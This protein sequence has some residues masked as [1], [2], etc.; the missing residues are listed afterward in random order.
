MRVFLSAA[1]SFVRCFLHIN[2][3]VHRCSYFVDVDM[4]ISPILISNFILIPITMLMQ[5]T[6]SP[7]SRQG[8]NR[9]VMS[10][11][12][13]ADDKFLF[14][15]TATGDILVIF[16]ASL[17]LAHIKKVKLARR[18]LSMASSASLTLCISFDPSKSL[19]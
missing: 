1:R 6:H 12:I 5:M 7:I 18:L 13:D 16:F 14:C 2:L 15:G 4:S 8:V 10:V 9:K 17:M 11:Q 19:V 3:P